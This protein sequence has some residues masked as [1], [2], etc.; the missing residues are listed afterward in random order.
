M[1]EVPS[2][3]RCKHSVTAR[4]A[5]LDRA[6]KKLLEKETLEQN[7]LETLIRETPK[8]ALRAV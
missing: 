4:R 1:M 7:D 3:E 8:E 5:I 2:Y 6:A